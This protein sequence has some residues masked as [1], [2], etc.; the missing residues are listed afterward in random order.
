MDAKHGECV[1]LYV[2]PVGSKPIRLNFVHDSVVEN[3]VKPV[4]RSS[5]NEVCTGIVR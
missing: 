4:I 1:R 5:G 3:S 2:C